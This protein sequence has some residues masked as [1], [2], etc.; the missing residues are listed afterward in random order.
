MEKEIYERLSLAKE[1]K[2]T[3]YGEIEN[4]NAEKKEWIVDTE[5][6]RAVLPFDCN[7]KKFKEDPES[8]VGVTLGFVICNI[9][10]EQVI[11]SHKQHCEN[12][13]RKKKKKVLCKLEKGQE[14]TCKIVDSNE[15]GIYV[16]IQHVSWLVSLHSKLYRQPKKGTNITVIV[17]YINIRNGELK[18]SVKDRNSFKK[19]SVNVDNYEKKEE[20]LSRISVGDRIVAK[21]VNLHKRHIRL[22]YNTL[23]CIIQSKQFSSKIF[24]GGRFLVNMGDE[25]ETVVVEKRIKKEYRMSWD[26]SLSAKAIEDEQLQAKK[27]KEETIA[28]QFKRGEVYPVT[29]KDFSK[30]RALIDAG[31]DIKSVILSEDLAGGRIPMEDKVFD[32]KQMDAMFLRYDDGVLYFGTKQLAE[33]PYAEELYEADTDTLLHELGVCVNSFTAKV[34]QVNDTKFFNYLYADSKEDRDNDTD[35]NLLCDNYTGKQIFLRIPQQIED[36]FT[37]GSFY[38][39]KVKAQPTEL[40]RKRECPFLFQLDEEAISDSPEVLTDPYKKLVK[41]TYSKQTSPGQS[42]SLAKL[43]V[44]VGDNMYDSKERMFFELLQNADDSSARKGVVVNLESRDGYLILTH[45]GLPFNRSDFVA[46]TAVARSNKRNSKKKT[47]Y[48]GIGFKSVF[49]SYRVFLKTGGFFFMFDKENELYNDFDKFYFQINNITDPERQEDFLE[50]YREEKK[51]FNG[52]ESIPWQLLPEW[53]DSVPEELKHTEFTNWDNVCIALAMTEATKGEY[54]SAINDVLSEPKFMLFL[55]NTNRINYKVGEHEFFLAKD[56]FG[57]VVTLQSTRV[58]AETKQN[59]VVRESE[60]VEVSTE[61]FAACGVDV[62]VK[63]EYNNRTKKNENKFVNSSGEYIDSIPQRIADAEDTL[64]SYA[65]PLDDNDQ[66]VPLDRSTTLFAYLPMTETRYPF[67]IYINADFIMKS[68]REGVQSENP[69]NHFLF[70]NIGKA[71]IGWIAKAASTTQPRYLDLLLA[72]YFD[73]KTTGMTKL[74]SYFNRGYKE[75][76]HSVPFILNDKG[77]LSCMNQIMLDETGLTSVIDADEYC[78]IAGIED[79]RLSYT[80]LCTDRLSNKEIYDDIQHIP[81]IDSRLLDAKNKKYVRGWMTDAYKEERACAFKWLIDNKKKNLVSALPLFEFD[82]RFYSVEEVEKSKNLLFLCGNLMQLDEVAYK[83]HLRCCDIDITNHPL[84]KHFFNDDFVVA[85]TKKALQTLINRSEEMVKDLTTK[86]K[87]LLFTIISDKCKELKLENL[88][89]KWRLF[90]NLDDIATPLSC[91]IPATSDLNVNRLMSSCI[92][93]SREKNIANDVLDDWLMKPDMLYSSYI[94]ENWDALLDKWIKMNEQDDS[95]LDISRIYSIVQTYYDAAE[96]AIKHNR[97]NGNIRTTSLSDISGKQVP[98]ILSDNK[99]LKSSDVFFCSALTDSSVYDVIQKAYSCTLPAKD[100]IEVLMHQPFKTQSKSIISLQPKPDAALELNEVTVL[101][102]C[103]QN[104]KEDFFSKYKIIEEEGKYYISALNAGEWLFY[105]SGADLRAYTLQN[106]DGAFALPNTLSDYSTMSGIVIASSLYSKLISAAT[107]MP[108]KLALLKFIV[109]ESREVKMMYIKSFVNIEISEKLFA[110]TPEYSTLFQ[111]FADLKDEDKLIET[112]RKEIMLCDA[113]NVKK[114]LS[115][116][117]MQGSVTVDDVVFDVDALFPNEERGIERVASN[118]L[119]YMRS[120]NINEDFLS[121][122][123]EL[124]TQLAPSDIYNKIQ[125]HTPLENKEQLAFAILHCH[126]NNLW[127]STVKIKKQDGTSQSLQNSKWINSDKDFVCTD[128]KLADIYAGV[129]PYLKNVESLP[130][131]IKIYEDVDALNFVKSTLTEDETHH[132]LDFMKQYPQNIN[133]D[134][135]AKIAKC[136]SLDVSK[137]V[138]SKENALDDEQLPEPVRTWVGKDDTKEKFIVETFNLDDESSRLVTLRKYFFTGSTNSLL[139][140]SPL[141]EPL[142]ERLCKWITAKEVC[143]DNR[144]FSNLRQIL[145]ASHLCILIDTENL[146]KTIVSTEPDETIGDF[147]IFMI[148]GNVP[149]TASINAE[150]V[151][152]RIYSFCEDEYVIVGNDIYVSNDVWHSLNDVLVKIAMDSSNRFSAENYLMFRGMQKSIS[153]YEAEE[154]Y[155]KLDRY[156][157]YIDDNNVDIDFED[158]NPGGI[159]NDQKREALEQARN[160]VI[161][162]LSCEGYDVSDANDDGWTI[163]RGIKNHDGDECPIVVRSYINNNRNFELN[164][165]DWELLTS[166]ENSMLWVV[167]N[168][169]CHCVSFLD[170]IKNSRD[171]I[172]FSFSTSNFDRKERITALAEVMRYFSGIHFDFGKLTNSNPMSFAK[173]FNEP[174]QALHEILSSDSIS[175]LP[176]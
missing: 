95:S 174:P 144:L 13:W 140:L 161:E 160:K 73:E 68:S 43:L 130:I 38:Q 167:M 81:N 64:L 1:R 99:F 54:V 14:L 114:K 39:I 153:P 158:V 40:R 109:Q 82:D 107:S 152:H 170:L 76:L 61:N 58:G 164:A 90:D 133:A 35:G 36:K 53:V 63:E 8:C 162:H 70:Y 42:A 121:N 41:Q 52:V 5:G 132:L 7:V 37:A 46:I 26:L 110:E 79:R 139:D 176:Q 30:S 19:Q 27:R 57:D 115:E 93:S 97:V 168:D 127:S 47:G 156:K 123:F 72:D 126:A 172:V 12:A 120:Q 9:D 45:D 62:V 84:Y 77:E 100:C 11:V 67:P 116:I 51:V 17:K 87:V 163:L 112:L 25:I 111:L 128:M 119:S 106:M 66:Y 2:E 141:D 171:R 6:V 60:E 65:I 143:F 135:T 85:N 86:E 23:V 80:S 159:S 91:M 138:V 16:E 89:S 134:N 48:K 175:N 34:T 150:K 78:F 3:V 32:G 88:I 49:K 165:G 104:N 166:E 69:W 24:A 44:E 129:M 108:Q 75:S 142:Q 102:E 71:Y 122:L 148:K 28:S 20:D 147:K 149:K 151:N 94:Y 136:I 56:K 146:E 154:L 105:N 169:G 74:S 157:R 4:Y 173:R 113:N 155:G 33:K 10:D 15:F 96:T 31:V 21:V 50:Q 59:Y 98:Y 83:L 117:S 55:R 29:V 18:L 124:K 131:G 125:R 145:T 137:V 103:C 92:I 22:K 118:I 101:L